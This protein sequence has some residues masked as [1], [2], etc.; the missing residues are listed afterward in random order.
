[1]ALTRDCGTACT[2]ANQDVRAKRA[3]RKRVLASTWARLHRTKPTIRHS[4]AGMANSLNVATAAAIML[5]E[6]VRRYGKRGEAPGN[7]PLR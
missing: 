2:P 7:P 1:V 4:D 3:T 5:H 6:P